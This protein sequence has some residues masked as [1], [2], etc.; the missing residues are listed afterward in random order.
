MCIACEIVASNV[1]PIRAVEQKYFLRV[2]MHLYEKDKFICTI[3]LEKDFSCR[4]KEAAFRITDETLERQRYADPYRRVVFQG[5][6]WNVT[7]DER[8]HVWC[9]NEP[10]KPL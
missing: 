3:G 10:T 1:V 9:I 2:R 7:N 5:D 6:L 8:V 4:D